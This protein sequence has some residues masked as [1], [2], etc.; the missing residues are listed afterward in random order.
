VL[1]SHW[2]PAYTAYTERRGAYK[3]YLRTADFGFSV[4]GTRDVAQRTPLQLGYTFEHGLTQAEPAVLCGVFLRCTPDEQEQVERR[5]PFAVANAAL[6]RSTTDNLV[7]PTRGYIAAAEL[8]YSAPWFASDPS[9]KFFKA[10]GDV[11][12]YRE[13]A[14]RITFAARAR[15]GFITGGSSSNGTQLPPP[16]ERLYAGGA[17]SVRGFQQNELGPQVYL[18]DSAG[19]TIKPLTD[20]T[21]AYIAKPGSRPFRS[22]PVGGNSSLVLN[23]ELRLRDPFVPDLLEYVPFLDAGQVW[24]RDVGSPHFNVN[25]LDY[26]P[27][28]AVRYFSPIG[29]IQLNAGYNR[30]GSRAGQAFFAAPVDPNTGK[31]PLIC[32]TAPGETLLP[33]T[34][35]N[36]QVTGQRG[37]ASCPNT[38]SPAPA[39]GF[40]RNLTLTLSINADF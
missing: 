32:V 2:T 30:Y 27:G 35:V 14:A 34:V 25:Q 31:A 40:F 9:Q 24:T 17:T 10:T 20:S 15:T 38:Y 11:S 16:Q 23:A 22:I 33:V 5:L 26:T 39:G 6:Q 21:V 8:R 28:L 4:T 37:I 12:W 19:I 7:E 1:G 36:G 3:A 13:I 29:P 18:L